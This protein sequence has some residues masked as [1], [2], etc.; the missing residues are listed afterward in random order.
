MTGLQPKRIY[1]LLFEGHLDHRTVDQVVD[2]FR[3]V[4]R[5]IEGSKFLYK[6]VQFQLASF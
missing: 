5:D 4:C 2:E 6:R 3:A 1:P